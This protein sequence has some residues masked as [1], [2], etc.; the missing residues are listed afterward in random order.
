MGWGYLATRPM[1]PACCPAASR[2]SFSVGFPAS[3]YPSQGML[4]RGEGVIVLYSKRTPHL[5]L[6]MTDWVW[7]RNNDDNLL[8]Q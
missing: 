3:W 6:N 2:T 1:S 4:G 8:V 7:R 5:A